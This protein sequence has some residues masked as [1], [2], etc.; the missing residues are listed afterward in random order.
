M[1]YV[2]NPITS[3]VLLNALVPQAPPP[4]APLQAPP[5]ADVIRAP[6]HYHCFWTA[7]RARKF[8]RVLL[9]DPKHRGTFDQNI[10]LIASK[11]HPGVDVR[12]FIQ[13]VNP[14]LWCLKVGWSRFTV[15]KLI[16]RNDLQ[17][18]WQRCAY[19]SCDHCRD[20]ANKY[21]GFYFFT[22]TPIPSNPAPTCV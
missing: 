19:S 3:N 12:L 5:V 21:S 7:T 20:L 22:Y 13:K 6:P 10:R 18:L 14:V 1:S 15:Q 8:A 9:N 4:M 2:A 16:V 17:T 11:T